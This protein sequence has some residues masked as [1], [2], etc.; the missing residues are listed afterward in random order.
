MPET[1]T[2]SA[3]LGGAFLGEGA[4]DTPVTRDF[5]KLLHLVAAEA[6]GQLDADGE[7]TPMAVILDTDD[8]AGRVA[9][10]DDNTDVGIIE[11]LRL[12]L[13]SAAARGELG[14]TALAWDA[15]ATP[16]GGGEPVDVLVVALDHAHGPSATA[17]IPYTRQSGEM[18]PE[19]AFSGA[20]AGGIFPA[21]MV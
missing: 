17:Y 4:P 20:G 18:M 8:G 15:L 16:E 5:A 10:Q 21:Q 14:A 9:V 11:L 2:I 19:D 6:A 1:E 7:I 3:S 13:Q 12:G